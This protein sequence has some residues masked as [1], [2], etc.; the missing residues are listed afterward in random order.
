MLNSGV[1]I[2]YA[3]L[4]VEVFEYASRFYH[5]SFDMNEYLI[6]N[7]GISSERHQIAN[8]QYPSYFGY[9]GALQRGQLVIQL[10]YL[11]TDFD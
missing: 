11:A 2:G 4:L 8:K 7:Y 3:G 5:S 1:C 9:L 10:T 6:S